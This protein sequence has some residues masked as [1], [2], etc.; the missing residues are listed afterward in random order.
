M[1]IRSRLTTIL[2][3]LRKKYIQIQYKFSAKKM[4]DVA[5]NPVPA[6]AHARWLARKYVTLWRLRISEKL[7]RRTPFSLCDLKTWVRVVDVYDGDTLK[8]LMSYRGKVDVWTVRMN[9]YDS[10]EMKPLKTH[11]NR[12]VEIAKAKRA[13]EVLTEKT[14]G[15][16]LFLCACGFDKYG[17]LL[18]EIY[19]G[20]LHINKYMIENGHG[21]VYQGGKKQQI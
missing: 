10:P 20:R 15:R 7:G 13:K 1:S 5:L 9:G 14:A 18:A 16:T 8:V 17:R 6:T 4:N 19:D 3:T 11:P 21:Y 12:E 2:R